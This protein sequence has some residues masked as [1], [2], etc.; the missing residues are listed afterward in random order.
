MFLSPPHRGGNGQRIKVA[1]VYTHTGGPSSKPM[2][3][4]G[5]VPSRI[6]KDRQPGPE[7]LSWCWHLP[8]RGYECPCLWKKSESPCSLRRVRKDFSSQPRPLGTP[9]PRPALSPTSHGALKPAGLEGGS[10]AAGGCFGS[11]S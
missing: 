3:P 2:R 7:M 1:T 9:E 11:V 5:H 4:S 6:R 10:S 8:G